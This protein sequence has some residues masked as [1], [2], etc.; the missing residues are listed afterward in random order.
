MKAKNTNTL[1]IKRFD[2]NVIASIKNSEKLNILNAGEVEKELTEIVLSGNKTVLLD[3]SDVKF[4]DSAGFQALLSVHI[5]A[6][7]NDVRF[8]IINVNDEINELFSLV[9]LDSIFEIE[10]KS[11]FKQIDLKQAS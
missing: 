7:L 2:D 5:D 9:D 3:F 4:L 11:G 6:R 1:T 8:I 10:T